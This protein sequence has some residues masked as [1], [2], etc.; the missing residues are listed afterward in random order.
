[1]PVKNKKLMIYIP[2]HTDFNSA[3]G[4]AQ[5]CRQGAE[6]AY[7]D[8]TFNVTLDIVISVNGTTLSE[9]DVDSL[10]LVSDRLHYISESI[11]AD[12]NINLG[13]LESLRSQSD[14]LWILSTNDVLHEDAMQNVLGAIESGEPDIFIIG[15]NHF[16]LSGKLTNAFMDDAAILPIG[17]ISAVIYR[18]EKFKDSFASAIKFSWTGWGQLSVIQN[19]LFEEKSLSYQVL[20]E[21]LIYDRSS[22]ISYESQL[23]KNQTFYRHSFFGYPLLVSILFKHD[24]SLRNSII[25]EWLNINWYKIG[26]FKVRKSKAGLIESPYKNAYWTQQLSKKY[27]IFSGFFSPVIYLIG[28]LSFIFSLRNY[29]ILQKIKLYLTQKSEI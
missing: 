1:V 19:T 27:I 24:K 20:Q 23:E 12:T 21:S 25:R 5:K 16:S 15:K 2:A 9:D 14:Y 8:S 26:Y 22:D 4:Q 29:K 13:Y 7:K 28:N 10:Q 3:I 17:L 11:G 6:P 18:T